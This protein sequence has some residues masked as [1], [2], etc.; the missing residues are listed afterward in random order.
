MQGLFERY[1]LLLTPSVAVLPF[2]AGV[3]FPG[4]DSPHPWD[5]IR[6]APYSFPFNLTNQPAASVP[7]GFSASGLPVGLQIVG[8]RFAEF[9]VLRAAAAFESAQPWAGR[10][11][12]L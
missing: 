9:T 1:D 11:P 10:R 5:W 4:G 8:R 12:P 6:W 7:A 3:L 2:E